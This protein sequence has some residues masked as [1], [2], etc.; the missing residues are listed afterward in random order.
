MV[1][2]LKV[3][4]VC[5]LP[6]EDVVKFR[7]VGFPGGILEG[8]CVWWLEISVVSENSVSAISQEKV[9]WES[10]IKEFLHG[11]ISVTLVVLGICPMEVLVCSFSE[12]NIEVAAANWVETGVFTK[13]AVDL[14]SAEVV[15]LLTKVWRDMVSP[16]VD[17]SAGL[18]TIPTSPLLLKA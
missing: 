4:V 7:E 11:E 10:E 1:L 3:S 9:P 8:K 18:E 13:Y 14:V 12:D 16:P 15:R 5:V 6:E 17:V 2:E